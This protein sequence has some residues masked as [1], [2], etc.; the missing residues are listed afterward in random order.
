[1]WEQSYRISPRRMLG[2]MNR[3]RVQTDEPRIGGFT[4]RAFWRLVRF[5]VRWLIAMQVAAKALPA[6]RLRAGF[7]RELTGALGIIET[8]VRCLLL[9]MRV[10]VRACPVAFGHLPGIF[11]CVSGQEEDLPEADDAPAV[12][13]GTLRT[14]RFSLYLKELAR[15]PGARLGTACPSGRRR[16]KKPRAGA[17]LRF[18]RRLAALRHALTQTEAEAARMA[19]W[20]MARGYRRRVPRPVRPSSGVGL[21]RLWASLGA[22]PVAAFRP[23]TS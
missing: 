5:S 4:H 23:D 9:E 13:D 21:A 2:V 14:P 1:M 15:R 7:I 6:G 11:R 18:D 3:Q 22:R 20:M 16:R 12:M 10:P 19:A 8:A 17:E